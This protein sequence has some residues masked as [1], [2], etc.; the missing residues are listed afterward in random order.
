M[1]ARTSASHTCG[2]ISLSLAVM[3]KRIDALFDTE[4]GINGM[5]T[6]ERLRV[7]HERS[8]LSRSVSV[9]KPID[10]MFKRWDR[11][12]RFIDDGRICLTNNAAERALRGIAMRESLCVPSS[13]SASSAV[14]QPCSPARGLRTRGSEIGRSAASSFGRLRVGITTAR[15]TGGEFIARIRPP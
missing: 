8:S 10:Y 7:R 4:R 6:D 9:A 12:A 3:I 11:F 2:S 5:N 14:A 13:V 1:R 15:C